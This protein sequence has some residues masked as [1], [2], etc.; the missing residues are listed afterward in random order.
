MAKSRI[1]I[2]DDEP[3]VLLTYSAILQQQGYEVDGATS[4]VE[5][6]DALDTHK[7]DVLLCDLALERHRSGFDVINYAREHDSGVYPI[8]LTGYS[9]DEIAQEAERRGVVVLFKPVQ[10]EEL[11]AIVADLVRRRK[12][13]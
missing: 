11:L 5:A 2:V 13:G 7:Y 3:S 9:T 10:I 6:R 4:W 1:L 12:A 8:L